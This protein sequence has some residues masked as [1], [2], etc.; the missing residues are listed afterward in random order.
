[1]DK[2]NAYI[3]TTCVAVVG[4]IGIVVG[5]VLAVTAVTLLVCQAARTER[6]GRRQ[7]AVEAMTACTA[8]ATA[9]WVVSAD[10]ARM[11]EFSVRFYR[12]AISEIIGGTTT[13]YVEIF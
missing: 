8:L 2:Q 6:S 9:A 13:C 5:G 1:M 3:T 12:S 11:H 7:P 10:A 4:I